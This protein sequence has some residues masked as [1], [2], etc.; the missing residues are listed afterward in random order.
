MWLLSSPLRID[1]EFHGGLY[2]EDTSLS[3]ASIQGE[4][5]AKRPHKHEDPA[6]DFFWNP[7]CVGP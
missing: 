7:P 4:L 6:N 1:I 3:S 2:A 5:G